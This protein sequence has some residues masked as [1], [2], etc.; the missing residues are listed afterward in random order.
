M[1]ACVS[2]GFENPDGFRFCGACGS[3]LLA[4]PAAEQ[5]RICTIIFCDLVGFTERSESLDPEDVRQFLLPYYELVTEEVQRYGGAIDKLYGD[6]VMAVFGVPTAHE[7]DPERAIRASL[8]M[9][10]RLPSL[11]LDLQARIGINTGEVVF[12]ADHAQRGDALTGDT[13]N[14]AS[15]IQSAAPVGCVVVG[16]TT[17]SSTKHVF[18]YDVLDPVALK[19][20]AEPVAIFRAVAPLASVAREA[21]EATPFVG[22]NEE[23]AALVAAFERVRSGEPTFVTLV[24]EPG[25]GK[26][27]LVREFARYVDG[28]PDLVTWREGRCPPYGQGI[29]FW[30]LG[31]IAKTHAGILDTDGQEAISARLDAVLTEPDMSTRSWMKDRLAPLV[32]LVTTTAAPERGELF[33]AWR[34]FITQLAREDPVVLVVEDLHWADDVLVEF[35]LDLRDSIAELPL[36]LLATARPEVADRHPSWIDGTELR[37]EPLSAMS[38]RELVVASLEGAS[39]DLL[40]RV[41][42]RAA[43]SPLYAEQ[44]AAMRRTMPIAGGSED[45]LPIPATIQALLG[46]RIDLLPEE[47]V[48]TLLDASVVGKRFWA[49][50][51]ATLG[52]TDEA[53]TEER[54]ARLAE[55]SFV[56]DEQSSTIE[57]EREYSFVHALVRDVAYGRLSRRPRFAKHRATATWITDRVGYPLGD[58]AEIVVAH[59]DEAKGA[60]QA[61]GLEGETA[62]LDSMLVDSLTDAARHAERTDARTA[63]RFA[64]R[65]VTLVGDDD[66]RRPD[67]LFLAAQAQDNT[68]NVARAAQLFEEATP[69]LRAAEKW[70]DLGEALRVRAV[71]HYNGGDEDAGSALMVSAAEELAAHPGRGLVDIL[72]DIAWDMTMYGSTEEGRSAIERTERAADDAGLPHPP[73]LAELRAMQEVRAGDV[74][75]GMSRW[76]RSAEQALAEG[77]AATAASIF[78]DLCGRGRW[79]DVPAAVAAG[80]RAIAIVSERGLDPTIGRGVRAFALLELGRWDEVVE[81]TTRQM[82]VAMELGNRWAADGFRMIAALVS[83]DRGRPDEIDPEAFEPANIAQRGDGHVWAI[84]VR[85]RT[86]RNLA[87][88][89]EPLRPV[90][91][92]D[93]LFPTATLVDALIERGEIEMAERCVHPGPHPYLVEWTR[94]LVLEARGNVGEAEVEL[95]QALDQR[96]AAGSIFDEAELLLHLGQCSIAL[97]DPDTALERLRR[98]RELWTSM[99]AMARIAESDRL[100]ASL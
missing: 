43:G 33:A 79:F 44:L 64:D 28:G 22:R 77:D 34:R 78:H 15:R 52:A 99:G 68:G 61:A 14:T 31:E 98:S 27:R 30:A 16:E 10:E 40:D 36:L 46:A 76:R 90:L 94:G 70:D 4:A 85:L 39:P 8:T 66:P 17:Y 25:L 97:G 49:G 23:F 11:G 86:M 2:C 7:D 55:R 35:L 47:L 19:G 21:A 29:S 18:D 89:L 80:E 54:L 72:R 20:K 12:S 92:A 26:S 13:V 3:M 71:L 96:V 75:T 41:C 32:G 1:I 45:D 6:G 53:T 82:Q 37:L 38:M 63:A 42:E 100:L 51:V 62:P 50:S 91:E 87:V 84:Y 69:G 81:E 58:V 56:N 57:G 93:E 24:A 5:R 59:L 60:A 73:R 95:Q 65:A 74:A 9:V 83:L 48:G 88:D 67:V